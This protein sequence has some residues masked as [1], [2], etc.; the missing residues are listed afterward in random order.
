MVSLQLCLLSHIITNISF[1]G[2][3]CIS[4]EGI[5]SAGAPSG[6]RS[7]IVCVVCLVPYLHKSPQSIVSS[8][9]YYAYAILD[10]VFCSGFL[11]M[12]VIYE[13]TYEVTFEGS[14]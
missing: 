13:V 7:L 3:L 6:C 11:I 12:A 14:F 1:A 8:A 5:L 10:F 4:V 2:D 9:V